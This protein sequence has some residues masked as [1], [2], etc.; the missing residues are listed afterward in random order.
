MTIPDTI[1]DT[2][3]DN[4]G[5]GGYA[6]AAPAIDTT[7]TQTSSDKVTANVIEVRAQTLRER[8]EQKNDVFVNRHYTLDV[9]ISTKTSA[10]QLTLLY[11]EVEYLLRNT[12]MT[13]IQLE[14]ID[15]DWSASEWEQGRHSVVLRVA[16]VALLSDGAV[17]SAAGV[18]AS[19]QALL[20]YGSANAAWVPTHPSDNVSTKQINDWD[21][22]NVG[23]SDFASWFVIPLACAKGSLKL[24]IAQVAI[25]ISDADADDYIDYI[26]IWGVDFSTP[27]ITQVVQ[28]ATN[29]DS[30]GVVTWDPT[31]RDM[32]A[33]RMALIKVGTVVTTAAELNF[34]F[35]VV[36]CYYDT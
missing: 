6:G 23:A 22:E 7:E 32:S 12:A 3:N 16:V 4:W 1:F 14:H 24:Y 34:S 28:D 33:Y 27:A 2:I 18:T 30:T 5:S 19:M 13:G 10:A 35:P 29:R 26:D 36:K 11:D 8:G 21:V 17:T 25:W 20:M 31:D 9:Y 15:K